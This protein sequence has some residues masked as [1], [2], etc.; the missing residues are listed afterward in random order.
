MKVSE[1][2]KLYR[3]VGVKAPVDIASGPPANKYNARKKLVSGILFDSTGEAEAY[4]YLRRDELLGIIFKLELQPTYVLQA[5]FRDS[6]GKHHRQIVYRADFRFVDGSGA[7][8]V[9]DFKGMRTAIF[10]LKLKLFR[11]K[12]PDIIFEQWTKATL[13]RL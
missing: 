7:I 11:A 8:H 12:Y 2:A 9:I 3:R 10:L 1:A 13:K 6:A 4:R 5:A